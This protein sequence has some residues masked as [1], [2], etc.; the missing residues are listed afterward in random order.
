MNRRA[1]LAALAASAAAT[2]AWAQ[3]GFSEADAARGIREALNLA[4]Q[5]ATSRLGRVDGFWSAPRVRIPLPSLLARTQR[6]LQ[7]MGMS[8]PLDD[9]QESLNH[10]AETTMPQAARLFSNA[11]R[12]ITVS[13]AIGIVRGGEDSATRYL[14]GRTETSLNGLLK[15]PMT[16]ALTQSGAFTLMRSALRQVGMASASGEV[17]TQIIDFSTQKALDGCFLYI[18]DEERQIRRDPVRRTT[19]IL[20]RVFGG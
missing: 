6:S 1:L 7:P 13:D 12:S 17:R 16:T 4:A 5:G 10:A 20:R 9:L 15:P 3:Y 18:A 8:G 11:I 19:S 14:R 2:P